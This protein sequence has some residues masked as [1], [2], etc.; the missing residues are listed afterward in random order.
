MSD[1][2]GG[3]YFREARFF[4]A[5]NKVVAQSHILEARSLMGYMRDMHALGGPAVQVQYATLQD[6]TQIK[7]TMMNGRY[8][9]EIVSPSLPGKKY[10]LPG[11]I[12]VR[13]HASAAGFAASGPYAEEDYDWL[14]SVDG[15]VSVTHGSPQMYSNR[16]WVDNST[17]EIYCVVGGKDRDKYIG[18]LG[19]VI[20]RDGLV[21]YT[22]PNLA[23]VA[24]FRGKLVVVMRETL[25]AGVSPSRER[26]QYT[27]LVAG[28]AV[29]TTPVLDALADGGFLYST[30]DYR[31]S[32]HIV[33]FNSTGAEGSCVL[34]NTKRLVFTLEDTE[35]G[36]QCTYAVV[37]IPGTHAT[38]TT[39]SGELVLDSGCGGAFWVPQATIYGSREVLDGFREYTVAALC[40]YSALPDTA[41][42]VVYLLLDHADGQRNFYDGSGGNFGGS[43]SVKVASGCTARFSTGETIHTFGLAYD[44]LN[45]FSYAVQNYWNEYRFVSGADTRILS[46]DLKYRFSFVLDADGV[47]TNTITS[48]IAPAAMPGFNDQT[49]NTV[50]W[51]YESMPSP[52]AVQKYTAVLHPS[53]GSVTKDVRDE[54]IVVTNQQL[55]LGNEDPPT[56]TCVP[57]DPLI[58]I[59]TRTTSAPVATNTLVRPRVLAYDDAISSNDYASSG[60]VVSRPEKAD[61]ALVFLSSGWADPVSYLLTAEGGV[62]VTAAFDPFSPDAPITRH[63]GITSGG[64]E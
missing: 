7:A 14:V 6:G 56:G 49:V 28:Q 39:V 5:G 8:Q 23:G 26:V 62:D 45:T 18:E 31:F 52:P 2:R 50:T 13:P 40:D 57:L 34:G 17:G 59:D 32:Q 63:F 30:A 64:S 46:V 22:A 29:L 38:C 15:E 53:G 54:R 60:F 44:E 35:E 12:W 21:I 19:S 48:T 1:E 42:Q 47:I 25:T 41:D 16:M 24:V 36:A 43:S 58:V 10:T 11:G 51:T 9:A 20:S 61:V 33:V 27:V 4:L 55:Y 37:T 3:R